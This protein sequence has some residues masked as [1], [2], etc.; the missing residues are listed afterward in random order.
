[1]NMKGLLLAGVLAVALVG[2][3]TNEAAPQPVPE[4]TAVSQ[5]G[6]SDKLGKLG[7]PKSQASQNATANAQ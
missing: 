3:A 2:C 5:S 1:M 4:N 7:A 6:Y